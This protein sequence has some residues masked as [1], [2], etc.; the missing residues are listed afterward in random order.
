MTTVI[1]D[2]VSEFKEN[3]YT[4]DIEYQRYLM[5][6][7]KLNHLSPILVDVLEKEDKIH[8]RELQYTPKFGKTLYLQKVSQKGL[9]F[10]KTT[11]KLQVWFGSSIDKLFYIDD[12]LKSLKKEWV[13]NEN[14]SKG[15]LTK[16]V[17]EKILSGKITNPTTCC[18][19]IIKNS[20]FKGASP[21]LLKRFI[22][23]KENSNYLAK[24]EFTRLFYVCKDINQFLLNYQNFNDSSYNDFSCTNKEKTN[25]FFS[26]SQNLRND[27]IY[28]CQVL[29][30]KIDLT[31]S[32][33]RFQE[34][35]KLMT[36]KIMEFEINKLNSVKLDY[37][38]IDLPSCFTIL[39]TELEVF[40]EGTNMHHCIYTNY[41]GK[42]KN[43]SYIAIHLDYKDIPVT[44]GISNKEYSSF[45]DKDIYPIEQIYSIG[46]QNV[47]DQIVEYAE[48]YIKKEETQ[49]KI[50]EIFKKKKIII[51]F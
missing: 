45:A 38:V 31:W 1:Q 36:E 2:S 14:F 8:F 35:H 47:S 41:W 49:N 12:F 27:I 4:K 6:T 3:Y 34:E 9:T 25:N 29:D 26:L 18:K 5:F 43:H 44:I 33:L 19:E 51:P 21:E 42:I 50:K 15:W 28:Q 7:N 32:V 48:F 30:K 22:K 40:K 37:P 39:D 13:I 20:R 46:N 11:K 17:L 16:T 10:N 24:K 23:Q